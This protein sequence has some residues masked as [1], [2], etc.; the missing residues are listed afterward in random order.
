[1]V[2]FSTCSSV[3]PV[4]PEGALVVVLVAVGVLVVRVGDGFGVRVPARL[5]A[6]VVRR[7]VGFGVVAF[8]RVGVAFGV[9]EGVVRRDGVTG[10]AAGVLGVADEVSV[11]VSGSS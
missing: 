10:V 8:G 5:G 7:G 9:T 1:L 3:V 4:P 2:S 6:D 11:I